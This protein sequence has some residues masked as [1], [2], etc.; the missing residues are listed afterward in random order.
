[1]ENKKSRRDVFG[2][3]SALFTGLMV[4]VGIRLIL[5]ESPIN[6]LMP[7]D[8]FDTIGTGYYL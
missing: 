3:C 6:C 8:M 5:A 4:F 1:M 2:S 7:I